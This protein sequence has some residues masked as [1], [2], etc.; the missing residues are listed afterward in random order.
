MLENQ[1][2]D[3]QTGDLLLWSGTGVFSRVIQEG[4]ERFFSEE[5][6]AIS[7]VGMVVRGDDVKP[8]A[9]MYGG[10]MLTFEST[11]LNEVASAR[12]GQIEA[13]VDLVPL[14]AKLAAY[15]GKCWVRRLRWPKKRGLIGRLQDYIFHNVGRPYE[16]RVALLAASAL[17]RHRLLLNEED[18][19][20]RFCSETYVDALEYWGAMD[21]R[22][23]DADAIC[24]AE[25]WIVEET[26]GLMPGVVFEPPE[27]L[28]GGP[29]A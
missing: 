16:E 8:I 28:Y 2:R 14:G 20:S 25:L 15:D 3:Y 5:A 29:G 9:P 13:G 10:R 7:H 26:C 22:A 6:A 1:L 17:P 24:P 4:Q 18:G 23:Q 19:S 12:T 21:E 11:T 27:L